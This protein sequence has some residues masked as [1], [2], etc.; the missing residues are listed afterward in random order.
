MPIHEQSL[1]RP[2]NLR[3]HEKL[4]MDGVDVSGHWSTFIAPRVARIHD[5]QQQSRFPGFG[6]S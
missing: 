5:M 6:E 2:E 3:T 4:V 1:I